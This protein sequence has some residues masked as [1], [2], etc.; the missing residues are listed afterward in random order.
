[1]KDRREAIAEAAITLVAAE[2]LRS[3]THR[4][5]DRALELPAGSTSYYARTRRQLIELM[6]HRL[7]A[8]TMTDMSAVTGPADLLDRLAE[9][10]DDHRVRYA[11]MVDLTGDPDLH[12]L[13]TTASP[14]QEA[15][16]AAAEST[17]AAAGAADPAR[18]APGLIAL[19]DG[20]LFDRVA[21]SQIPGAAEVIE[22]YLRGIRVSDHHGHEEAD[23][24]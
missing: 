4:A 13:L 7:A 22:A 12:P 15:F 5:I 14:A 1:M 21:G 9:R 3:L 19:V 18:H 24:E 17:L 20:L 16:L 2:G 8:R 6:V 11:L 23:P 10:A